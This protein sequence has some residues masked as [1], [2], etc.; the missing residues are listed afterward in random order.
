MAPEAIEPGGDWRL[1]VELREMLRV[2]GRA[3]RTG[4]LEWIVQAKRIGADATVSHNEMTVF[5]YGSTAAGLETAD[6][7]I[8]R[9]LV[10]DGR[11]ARIRAYRWDDPSGSWQEFDPALPP[12]YEPAASPPREPITRTVECSAGRLVSDAYIK[13]VESYARQHGIECQIVAK[14]GA[15]RTALEITVTGPEDQVGHAL[16]YIR[17]LARG[18]SRVDPGLIPYGGF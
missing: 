6:R 14:R 17:K 18:S 9:A 2:D 5:A 3:R 11:T 4:E 15:F 1:L 7:A 12:G 10:A 16:T 13:D 8:R